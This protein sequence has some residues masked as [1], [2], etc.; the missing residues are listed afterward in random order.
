MVNVAR[1]LDSML[2]E[3]DAAI[4]GVAE[5]DERGSALLHVAVIE[6]NHATHRVTARP[7]E[8]S[9]ELR[10]GLAA[11]VQIVAG[12][13]DACCNHDISNGA[14]RG[15]LREVP[16]VT[17][18]AIDALAAFDASV[19]TAEQWAAYRCAAHHAKARVARAAEGVVKARNLLNEPAQ[20]ALAARFDTAARSLRDG[21]VTSAFEDLALWGRAIDL[22]M[23]LADT[24]QS[25]R[26]TREAMEQLL[27]R[28]SPDVRHADQLEAYIRAA[29][30]CAAQRA[31][32]DERTIVRQ[33]RPAWRALSRRSRI[34]AGDV[35][36]MLP[37]L[38]SDAQAMTDPGL[39]AGLSA[40][41]EHLD[42]LAMLERLSRLLAGDGD[43]RREP[44]ADASWAR[45]ADRMLRLA[46]QVDDDR[47][48]ASAMS[49][50][51]NFE[52]RATMIFAPGGERD[53]RGVCEG[54]AGE[55]EVQAWGLATDGR[56]AHLLESLETRRE[57]WRVRCEGEGLEAEA[58]EALTTAR[59]VSAASEA[60]WAMRAADVSGPRG[61]WYVSPETAGSLASA[62]VSAASLVVSDVLDGD[63]ARAGAGATALETSHA[64]SRL[65]ARIEREATASG[66]ISPSAG[67]ALMRLLCER[68]APGG[69]AAAD[70]AI[71]ARY[72]GD[73][74]SAAEADSEHA[75][76]ARAWG[77]AAAGRALRAWSTTRGDGR[78]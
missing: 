48:R 54:A 23:S 72:A 1:A 17:D 74:A 47:T 67:A 52:R 21:P 34:A 15:A 66:P 76:L 37:N 31:I 4:E 50:L 69:A 8:A 10:P 7:E 49:A 65:M 55:V 36:A 30:L 60:V 14:A 62:H 20:V 70:L 2:G 16:G 75:R 13:D 64:T 53:L 18:A 5:V 32:A 71:A 78:R 28:I 19:A 11:I 25:H 27:T 41:R 43:A 46:Q 45:T 39:L 56:A 24:G 35:T 59:A 12:E 61:A 77:E 29:E 73:A 44:V 42:A 3:I 51:A 58:D 22:A 63:I 40:L 9:R 26:Q 33:L 6:L 68:D 38:L 57:A